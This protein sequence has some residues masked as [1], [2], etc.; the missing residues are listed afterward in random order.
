MN[1]GRLANERRALILEAVDTFLKIHDAWEADVH[2]PPQ[3]SEQFERAVQICV[4]IC[5]RG[6]Q[7]EE[8]RALV[9]A[10]AKMGLEWALYQNG[11]MGSEYRPTKAFWDAVREVKMERVGA[12]PFKPR[13]R[14]TVKM[15]LDQ[16]VGPEQIARANFADREWPNG[17]GPF[18]DARGAV[19]YDALDAERRANER[20]E[21][22]L[23]ADWIHPDDRNRKRTMDETARVRLQQLR[24][25]TNK[26]D[27][28]EDPEALL[29][30]GQYANVVARVCGLPLD[31]VLAIAQRLGLD[32]ETTP[33]LAA[34]RAPSE[35]QINEAAD[36]ALQPTPGPSSDMPDAQ[37]PAAQIQRFRAMGLGDEEI[38]ERLGVSP[39]KL[40]KL[41]AAG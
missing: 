29:R 34:R 30:E 14:E 32:V 40:R 41:A 17:F 7:P 9:G 39:R 31:D 13:K 22:T 10:V 1:D 37:T 12:V 27:S 3:P 15:L 4:E 28:R 19:D 35:P 8:C 5:E 25:E 36:R 20:G 33:N 23:P 26:T 16:K 6:D 18:L 24:D 2:G 38:A 11:K 21:T